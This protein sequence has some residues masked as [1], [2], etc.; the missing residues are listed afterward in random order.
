VS[1][2]IERRSVAVL[3]LAAAALFSANTGALPLPAIDD[4]FYARKGVEMARGGFA[5]TVTWDG[6]ATFQNPPLAFWLLAAS[7]R[8]FG[9]NDFAA[10]A[11]SILMALGIL[12]GVFQIGRRVAGDAVGAAAVAL[13]V[14][15]PG[16]TNQTHRC[17]L[18]V[19]VTFWVTAAVLVL[20][21]GRERPQWLPWLALPLGAAILT[22]SLLGLLPLLVAA[23]AAL[24]LPGFR[25]TLRRPGFLA[26]AL[27]GLLIGALWPL[28]QW[29]AV[30][31]EALQ[32]H[33]LEEIAARAAEPFS[34]KE[35]FLHYPRI[36]LTLYQ[37][38]ILP[39]LAGLVVLWRERGDRQKDGVHLLALWMVLPILV[40]NLS[41]ARST[42]YV[43]PTLPALALVGGYWLATRLPRWND[44]VVKWFTP[45]VAAAVAILFWVKPAVLT[46]SA[47]RVYKETRV[48]RDRVPAG[49]RVA[50]LGEEGRYWQRANPLLYYQERRLDPPSRTAA[51]AVAQALS[52]SGLLLVEAARRA[53]LGEQAAAPAV[54]EGPDFAILD[55]R[56]GT[57][58]EAL[59]EARP[60]PSP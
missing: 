29:L 46:R 33:Y 7:D 59:G 21:E 48:V 16:L 25:P 45:L 14:L 50:Y 40:Y 12:A 55:L 32:K 56:A 9:E 31:P 41:S 27:G 1:R 8:I 4:C 15:T 5:M 6:E 49:E 20:V 36:L 42:R 19:P 35:F 26:G 3:F 52:R 17:M 58:S 34:F 2:P 24:L 13:L 11:P 30:G 53:E 43:Y 39:A 57:G 44:H 54:L 28:H 47:T 10:R 23:G 18:E 22:K 51:D 60:D 38:V 37:P